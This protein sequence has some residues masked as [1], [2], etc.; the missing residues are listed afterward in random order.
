MLRKM[1]ESQPARLGP[2]EPLG[3]SRDGNWILSLVAT[4]PPRLLLYPTGAGT[5]RELH[6]GL[7]D[8]I[9]YGSGG[10]LPDGQQYFFCASP[11][12]AQPRCF[13]AA[14]AG[15]AAVAVTPNGTVQARLS[16]DGKRI[17]AQVGDSFEVFD[18]AGGPGHAL[19]GLAPSDH[20]VRWSPDNSEVWVYRDDPLVLHVDRVVIETGKRSR[21]VDI[22]PPAGSE[23]RHA[24]EL[25]LNDN[26]N[27]YAYTQSRYS[28]ALFTVDGV[29]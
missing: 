27:I 2:G 9:S 20:L 14:T 23:L 24:Y 18:I 7:F 26:P 4:S 28:S 10:M 21:L 25:Q 29:R 17:A 19:R 6:P 13:V 1:D 8:S 3:F 12:R 15:G 22:A 5:P 16:P 11:P